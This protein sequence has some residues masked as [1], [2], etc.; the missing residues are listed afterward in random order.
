MSTIFRG[1]EMTLCQIYFQSEAAYT[2][3]AQLGELDIVQ[4]RDVIDFSFFF[5]KNFI[6]LMLL[7]S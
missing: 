2:C 4:F 7:N 5:L 1:E 3:V 6:I